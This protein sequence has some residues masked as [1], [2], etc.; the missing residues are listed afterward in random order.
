MS[1]F[2]IEFEIADKPRYEQ[3]VRVVSAICEA[4]SSDN[5]RDDE[6]WLQFFDKEARV[7]FW[8]PTDEERA[9]WLKRWQETPAPRRFGDPTLVTPWDFGSMIDAFRNAGFLL[10]GCQPR[11][12]SVARLAFDPLSEPH[13]GP[14]CLVAL[15][16]AFGHTVTK[17]SS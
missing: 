13:G 2:F 17:V 4:K 14:D 10:L 5:W 11:S 3:L 16:E 9:Q 7:H 15:V 8:W 12:I 1:S 6:Y